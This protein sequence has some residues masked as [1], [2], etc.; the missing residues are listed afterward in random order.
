MKKIFVS[1]FAVLFLGMAINCT[2][3]QK[4]N[5]INTIRN[6]QIQ[7]EWMLVAFDN[8]TK[9]DLVKNNAKIN[10][11]QDIEN[12]KIKGTAFMGC[13]SMFFTSEF[14]QNGDVEISD[15]GS[16]M[17]ACAEMKLETDFSASF[18]NMKKYSVQGHFLTLS[19]DNGNQIKFVAAD[20]D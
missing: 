12:G 3:S 1:F 16:T 10:L 8:Y 15:I 19:D 14:K 20:W 2:S 13:N 6:H 4:Q 18:K 9:Q 5:N 11:T 17:K 7:R